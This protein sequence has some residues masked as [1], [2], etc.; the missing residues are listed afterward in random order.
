MK[1]ILLIL[2]L[3]LFVSGQTRLYQTRALPITPLS[4][5]S[6]NSGWKNVNVAARDTMMLTAVKLAE[7]NNGKVSPIIGATGAW[8]QLNYLALSPPLKAQ[9]INGTFIGEI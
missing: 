9:I 5:V 6:V 3:P 2:L 1:V 8:S 7:P 4:L